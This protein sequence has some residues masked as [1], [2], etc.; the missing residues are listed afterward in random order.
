MRWC[1]QWVGGN[2]VI[3]MTKII[4]CEEDEPRENHEEHREPKKV[5]HRII[6]VERNRIFIRLHI[7]TEWIVRAMRME[8]PDMHH[9]HTHQKKRHEIMQGEEAIKRWIINREP[10]PQ[11]C[12]D[13]FT[14]HRKG[15]EQI[16]NYCCTPKTHL[17]PWKNIAHKGCRH[18]Q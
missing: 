1:D 9:D 16:G 17:S 2:I 6:G 7:N 13:R 5:F 8:R 10:A 18:H 4:W 11:P 14:H 3:R 15:G 12:Y